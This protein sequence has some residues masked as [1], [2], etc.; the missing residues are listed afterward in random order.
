MPEQPSPGVV[1]PSSH[2]SPA[3]MIPS[4]H[5]A[6]GASVQ[7]SPSHWTSGAASWCPASKLIPDVLEPLSPPWPPMP[8]LVVWVPVVDVMEAPLPPLPVGVP[9]VL[10]PHAAKAASV[11]SADAPRSE[12]RF[13]VGNATGIFRSALRWNF[14]STNPQR[15]R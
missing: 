9:W 12:R 2:V 6:A 13:I 5:T 7:L 1:L 3:S 11:A 14:R 4:P 8:L 10:P 15:R